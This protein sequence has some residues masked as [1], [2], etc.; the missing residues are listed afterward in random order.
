MLLLQDLPHRGSVPDRWALCTLLPQPRPLRAGCS[1]GMVVPDLIHLGEASPRVGDSGSSDS[2]QG[3]GICIS[4]NLG[5]GRRGVVA[6]PQA[7]TWS[8]GRH[9]PWT[10]AASGSLCWDCWS[11]EK[12]RRTV[13]PQRSGALLWHEAPGPT[14]SKCLEA[15]LGFTGPTAE[16]RWPGTVRWAL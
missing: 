1:L 13:L 10:Q 5:G 12:G 11:P 2:W 8:W 7:A 9:R 14:K 15:A 16:G 3:P 4:R 6:G